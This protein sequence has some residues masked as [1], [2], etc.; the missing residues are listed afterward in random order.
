MLG[1]F[2]PLH[3]VL[4]NRLDLKAIRVNPGQLDLR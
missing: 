1:L 3:I 4:L 2:I